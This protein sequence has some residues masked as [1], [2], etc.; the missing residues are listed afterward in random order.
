MIDKSSKEARTM[1]MMRLPPAIV[2]GGA[3]DDENDEAWLTDEGSDLSAGAGVRE[4]M[5]LAWHSRPRAQKEQM[6]FKQ[7]PRMLFP[8]P[9]AAPSWHVLVAVG[10]VDSVHRLNATVL[11]SL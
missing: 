10:A 4:E 2:I 7:E 6:R 8:P 1:F 11:A 9:R 5:S 3:A